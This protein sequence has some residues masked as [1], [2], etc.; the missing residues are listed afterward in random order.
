MQDFTYLLNSEPEYIEMMYQKYRSNPHEIDDSWRYFFKGY[1]FYNETPNNTD[2]DEI[3][4]LNLINNYRSRGH[5]FTKT[6]PVRKRR[7]YTP[8][9]SLKNHNLKESDLQ[10]KFTAGIDLLGKP[11][12]LSEIIETL[13]ETYCN[14]IGAEF[15]FIREPEKVEW[16]KQ[17]MESTKNKPNF[18]SKLKARIHE[19]LAK[20]VLFEQFL[21]S[22]YLGQKRFSLQGGE[23]LIPGLKAVITKGAELGIEEFIIGMPHRGRLNVLANIMDKDLLEIFAEF[24]G[25]EI[26]KEDLT[27]IG[28]DFSGDVKYHLGYSKIVSPVKNKNIKL[29]LAPNPSHLEAVNPVVEGMVR[30]KID[31]D[32]NGD[33]SK[34]APILIHGDAAIAGQGVVYEVIQMAKLNGYKTGGTI[35]LVVNN[36]IGFTTDYTDGR[37]STYC[38]DVAKVTL[39]P[40]F[41]VN[42]DDVEAVVLAIQIAMEYRQKFNSDVF[43][44]LLGY[45]KYGHNEGDEPR[46]TQPTLYKIIENHIDPEKIY[47]EKLM[48]EGCLL[49]ETIVDVKDKI[50][51]NFEQNFQKSK[52]IIRK[53]N[54][55]T[56]IDNCDLKKRNSSHKLF[57]FP[58]T[59]VNRD[60]IKKIGR[61]IFSIPNDLN[62]ISKLRK[63][64]EQR[65]QKIEFEENIDW[66]TAEILTYG[67]LLSEGISVRLSGQD[68]I[69][70]TFSHRHSAVQIEDSDSKIIL[71]NNATNGKS[72]FNVYNSSLSEFGV[73]GFEYGYACASPDQ[74]TI[75]EAQFGDFHNGAQIII[76][77]FISSAETKWNRSN[78][79]VMFLPHG[80]EGQGPEHS[81]ARIER[82]LSLCANENMHVVN[83]TTPA[84]L[85]HLLRGHVKHNFR[86]PLVVFTPKSLL[87]HPSCVSS[88]EDL[89]EGQ[90]EP[91]ISDT[92]KCN[93]TRRTV[94]VSGKLFYDL[95]DYKI[96]NEITDI[97]I[98]RVEQLYPFPKEKIEE[99][100]QIENAEQIIWAQEEPENFGAWNFVN[101]RLKYHNLIYIGRKESA[102][103]AVG[104]MSQHIS[105]QKNIIDKVFE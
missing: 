55:P 98:H 70:G 2:P 43:I 104:S 53:L 72:S 97:S 57:P 41:H 94:F 52:T 95:Q 34:I 66:G 71:L 28:F 25:R 59:K 39:S 31:N 88:L 49:K 78:G 35:H 42:A 48:N 54:T 5:L 89:T 68:S 40:V 85:F 77:Q 4:V 73:L 9:L 90:F 3:K 96:K 56:F 29:G 50:K 60:E 6:N 83:P 62:V 84:N 1:E 14:S 51:K 17:K 87:R 26:D 32:Y 33:M 86:I 27:D 37:S 19:D 74:L 47:S 61:S 82:F 8:D 11:A 20:A 69:R 92:S 105:E 13:N 16:L 15:M 81:S 46:F 64:Y 23:T 22:K 103:P 79:L 18:D 67:T 76:D 80:F 38:T 30:A 36:Q 45:R 101:N 7:N 100:I 10:K 75:W 21:H 44:D 58:K 12:K 99:I 93:K 91:I 63:L 24:E 65:L 102:T